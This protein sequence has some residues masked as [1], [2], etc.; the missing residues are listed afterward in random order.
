MGQVKIDP[1]KLRFKAALLEVAEM[2][3]EGVRFPKGETSTNT[4]CP[5]CAV[6]QVAARCGIHPGDDAYVLFNL[7]GVDAELIYYPNDQRDWA[8]LS[9]SLRQASSEIRV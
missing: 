1:L 6:G 9:E 4:G 8:A 5:A 7:Y 3:E 2:V